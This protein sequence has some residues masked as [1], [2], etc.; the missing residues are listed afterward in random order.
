MW[1]YF[2][3]YSKKY[4]KYCEPNSKSEFWCC[5]AC[6]IRQDLC[7]SAPTL[8]VFQC[9]QRASE[10]CE[11]KTRT[12]EKWDQGWNKLDASFSVIWNKKKGWNSNFA[13]FHPFSPPPPSLL[14]IFIFTGPGVV[15]R[16]CVWKNRCYQ[17]RSLVNGHTAVHRLNQSSWPSQ[18]PAMTRS[19][20]PIPDTAARKVLT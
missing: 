15:P 3:C 20:T 12:L 11:A 8:T 2:Q 13:E 14:K 6:R 4:S 5:S 9:F 19:L 18:A 7:R 1:H 10:H 16:R 17:P